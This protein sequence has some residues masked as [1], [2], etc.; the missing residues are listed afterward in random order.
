M[1]YKAMFWCTLMVV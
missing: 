1:V